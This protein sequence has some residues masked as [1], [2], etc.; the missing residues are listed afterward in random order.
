MSKR[1]QILQL[2]N[3]LPYRLNAVTQVVSQGLARL[4]AEDFG[5]SVPEWRVMTALGELGEGEEMTA[6]DIAQ[7]SRMGKVMTSRAVAA[8]GK[9]KFLARRMNREDRRESFLRLSDRG[10]E[11]YAQIVPRALAY[12]ARLEKGLS[13]A[14]ADALDRIITHLLEKAEDHETL[15]RNSELLY[16]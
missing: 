6:R 4:Y 1:T 14:D 5:I 2:N 15:Q 13:R 16:A 9:R 10:R 3:F 11:I 8:L 12:Q 7:H